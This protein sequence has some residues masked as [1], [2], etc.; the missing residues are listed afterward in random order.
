MPPHILL[1]FD[2]E[3]PEEV[4]A[5][6]GRRMYIFPTQAYISLYE[7]QGNSIVTDQVTRLAQLIAEAEGR[8]EGCT[9]SGRVGRC[10]D[11]GRS[12]GGEEGHGPG[13][14]DDPNHGALPTGVRVPRTGDS[15][16]HRPCSAEPA[17]GGPGASL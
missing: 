6:H 13:S 16:H 4:L 3:S 2:G 10:S 11:D 12:G 9:R 15:P 14:T 17:G 7:S 5:N 1:T 8:S